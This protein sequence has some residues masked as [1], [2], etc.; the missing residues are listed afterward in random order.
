MGLNFGDLD[1]DGF[2]DFYVGTG[3]PDLSTV[4]PNRMFRN[5]GKG[6]FQDVTTAGNFGH[7]QK[8]H[9]IAFGDVDGDG[10]QDI[11]AQMGGAYLTDTAYSTLY[12]NPGSPG[13]SWLG[14]R[15][16]GTRA[17]R[18]AIG[19]RIKVVVEG[20]SGRR[21]IYRVV[22]SGGSFGANPLRQHI[23]V[24]DAAR[25]VEVEIRWP[26]SGAAERLSDLPLSRW[27]EVREGA[28]IKA[29]L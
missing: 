20:P 28:R 17:N 8:G 9:G 5:S 19:A 25:V 15:L 14:L 13:A 7:V 24:G 29:D 4:V 1:S 18:S 6:F 3:N 21:E 23:G 16:V 26:G 27:H 11:F 22:S 2:L 12:E 10:D